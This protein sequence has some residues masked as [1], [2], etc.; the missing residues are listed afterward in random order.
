MR[1]DALP[2]ENA[3]PAPGGPVLLA[4]EHGAA[5]E[6]VQAPPDPGQCPPG[7][8][9]VPASL[10]APARP[11]CLCVF[12]RRALAGSLSQPRCSPAVLFWTFPSALG[13][14]LD[15]PRGEGPRDAWDGWWKRLEQCGRIIAQVRKEHSSS[16]T[17]GQSWC[18]ESPR[19]SS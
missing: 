4:W 7:A 6:G 3:P 5:R 14:R 8:P 12:R 18:S 9:E 16:K 13:L 17:D 15:C 10:G 1:G 11:S 19:T 2:A